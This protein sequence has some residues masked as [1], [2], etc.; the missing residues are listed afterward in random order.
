MTCKWWFNYFDETEA[1]Y[2][3]SYSGHQM[4][5]QNFYWSKNYVWNKYCT[6]PINFQTHDKHDPDNEK[7]QVIYWKINFNMILLD[8]YKK[9][10]N[11][12]I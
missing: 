3:I 11:K 9:N 7:V 4:N 10:I 2:H 1:E 8:E 5:G 12:S 6:K